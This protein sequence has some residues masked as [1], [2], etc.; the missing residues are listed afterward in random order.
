MDYIK[1]GHGGV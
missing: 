1:L